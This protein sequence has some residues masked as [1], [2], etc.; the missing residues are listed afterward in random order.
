MFQ[1]TAQDSKTLARNGEIQTSH[2]L[3]KTPVFMPVGTQATV[4]TLHPKDLE[5]L[6]AS[7]ILGNTYH[8]NLRPSTKVI[9][10]F[11]GLHNFMHWQKPILTDSGGFQVWSLAKMRKIKEEG[12]EFQSHIDGKKIFLSPESCMEIQAILG[13]DIAMVL[14]ECP[15]YPCD[16]DYAKSSMELSLRWAERC[17]KWVQKNNPQSSDGKQFHFGIIQGSIYADL[18]KESAIQLSKMDF[19]GYAVGGISVGEPENEMLACIENSFPFLPANKP[20]Y[21]MGL[22]TPTQILEMIERGI[23]MFDCVIPTRLARHGV[24]LLPE[25]SINLKNSQFSHDTR[26]LWQA[27]IPEIDHFSRAYI[28]HLLKAK[29]IL[30]LRILSFHNLFFLIKLMTEARKAI[31]A[32]E[33]KIFKE[34][35]TSRYLHSSI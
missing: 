29:E 2:G 17:K 24:A 1:I 30:A 5:K 33:F 4:K 8:L 13:S 28:H 7:I 35:F 27:G 16:Y 22:G 3:I 18:R 11:G 12:V 34:S 32:G 15:P 14:D 9:E 21:A 26:E 25:G 19:D 20:R 23:D 10:K 6:G 31:E